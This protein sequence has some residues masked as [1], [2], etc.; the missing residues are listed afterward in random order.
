MSTLIYPQTHDGALLW[1]AVVLSLGLHLV[2]VLLYPKLSKMELPAIPERME[3][4]FFSTK[5]PAPAV[6]QVSPPVE[7][8]RPA[9]P[10]KAEPKPIVKPVTPLEAPKP[11]LAAPKN[12]DSD[13]RV[14]E[15]PVQP[16]AK[17]EPSLAPPAP[18]NM[19]ESAPHAAAS[20]NENTTKDNKPSAAVTTATTTAESDELSASDSD[21]WGDY[22]E[23]LRSLVNK[24][25]QY[26]AIAIRRHLEGEATVVAQFVRGELVNV[27]VADSSKH[28]SL[29]EE[30]MR[31]VKKAIAQLGV[32]DSLKKKSFKITIPVSFKLE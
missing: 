3:I 4:E 16:P 30:A 19:A 10:P 18:S 12:N 32:K 11:I 7:T 5:A 27:T 23:Q 6:Q 20:S 8:P 17:V 29:D 15:Q 1:R 13:Y 24:S 26:P 28:V 25:K 31:M 14:Q 21:A 2:V 22:G 9:E